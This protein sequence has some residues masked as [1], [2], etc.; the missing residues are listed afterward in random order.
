MRRVSP[1]SCFR[2]LSWRPR[3]TG[4]GVGGS[5]AVRDNILSRGSSCR[6]L[7]WSN[8]ILIESWISAGSSAAAHVTDDAV[9]WQAHREP[10]VL[11]RSRH[12]CSD[13]PRRG[14]GTRAALLLVRAA[15]LLPLYFLRVTGIHPRASRLRAQPHPPSGEIKDAFHKPP[16]AVI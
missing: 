9:L 2:F 14:R 10:I 12:H 6:R 15:P 3:R 4:A 13:V 5:R 16:K 7:R 8:G 1:D 11:T